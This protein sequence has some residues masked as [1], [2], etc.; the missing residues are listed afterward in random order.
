MYIEPITMK[1]SQTGHGD[2]LNVQKAGALESRE[3]LNG[4]AFNF[5]FLA[6]L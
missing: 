6:G 5:I 1:H 4:F 3:N 2:W